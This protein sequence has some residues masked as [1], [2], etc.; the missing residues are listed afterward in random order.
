[1]AFPVDEAYIAKL[2]INVKK[3]E[4]LKIRLPYISVDMIPFYG[5]MVT[6][7]LS[8]YNDEISRWMNDIVS[9]T[10]YFHI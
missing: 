3:L 1:V 4:D 5:V 9:V 10:F 8:S 6:W 2:Q 7:A